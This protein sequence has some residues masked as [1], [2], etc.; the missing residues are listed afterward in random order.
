MTGSPPSSAWHWR[1]ASPAKPAATHSSV[2][3]TESAPSSTWHRA[4]ASSTRPASTHRSASL[5]GTPEPLSDAVVR[6]VTAALPA[7]GTVGDGSVPVTGGNVACGGVTVTAGSVAVTGGV[8]IGGSVTVT[9]GRVAVTGGS[10]GATTF[11]ATRVVALT[12]YGV[13]ANPRGAS[14]TTRT[15]DHRRTRDRRWSTR[16]SRSLRLAGVGVAP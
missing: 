10:A 12:T 13:A 9:R 5:V 4:K 2:S 15:S 6:V 1:K 7:D 14:P 16:A 11:V 8:V 3:T